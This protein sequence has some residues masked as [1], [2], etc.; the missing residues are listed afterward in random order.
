M[1]KLERKLERI[2]L[3]LEELDDDIRYDSEAHLKIRE[4][5]VKLRK[6]INISDYDD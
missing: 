2:K 1:N 5:L 4:A 3:D 6:I